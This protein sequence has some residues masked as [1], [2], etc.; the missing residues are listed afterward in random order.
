MSEANVAGK[1]VVTYNLHLESKSDD[2]LRCSQLE[3]TLD[4]SRR[5]DSE[6]PILLAGDL[7]LDI[8]SG[9][10]AAA[11]SRAQFRDVF[12]NQ[13]VPTT[14]GSFLD[15]GRSIDWIF[16]SGPTRV[17]QPQVHRLVSA[18]DHFPLSVT[19]AFD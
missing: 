4:D 9:R 3:E 13:H 11:I 15:P 16:T 14:P 12:G 19:L 2:D 17:R 1:K 8:S 7:N 6:I 10:A 5:Y 18:S